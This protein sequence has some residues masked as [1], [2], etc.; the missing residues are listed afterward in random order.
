M[1]IFK[2]PK[3]PVYGRF[4]LINDKGRIICDCDDL[5][6]ASRTANAYTKVTG[7]KAIVVDNT[8]RVIK[9]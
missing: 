2:R 6:E 1:C 5:D 3:K 4:V 7:I 8:A 9:V